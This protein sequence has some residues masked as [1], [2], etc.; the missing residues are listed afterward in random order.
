MDIIEIDA[1][2]NTGIDDIRELKE[3]VSYSPGQ[4]SRKMYI[5]DEVHM[6]STNASNALLKTLEEPPPH[7]IFVLATTEVHKML[8]TLM[9][10]CQ[11]FDFHRITHTD[12]TTKLIR[13]CQSEGIKIEPEALRLITRSASGSL[14]DAENLTEQLATYYGAEIG[15]EQTQAMLGISGD[16]RS[17]ELVGHIIDYNTAAAIKTLNAVAGDG[18][19]LKQ[20]NRELVIYLRE[21]LLFKTGSEEIL[22]LTITEKTEIETLVAKAS[23]NHILKVLKFFSSLEPELDS[24]STL[25]LELVV[26]DACLASEE[27]APK[28]TTTK[29]VLP[30]KTVVIATEAK[31]AGVA[32]K[33]TPSPVEKPRVKTKST[34]KTVT[35]T[36]PVEAT[37][38]PPT[39]AATPAIKSNGGLERLEQSWKEIIE[40]APESTRRTPALAILRSAGVHPVA[41]S[42]NTVT[43][44]FKHSYHKDKI[45]EPENK[46]VVIEVISNFLGNPCQVNCVFEREANHLV[47]EAQKLGGR[48]IDV[49]EK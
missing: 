24:S 42:D 45:E 9:S 33:A 31:P 2:S 18:L 4:A 7:V 12:I 15:L 19:D 44:S 40:Q 23:L 30:Q 20:F 37:P 22:N 43:L 39:T 11:R 32:K 46:K 13:I 14:R 38:S 6:L 21:L 8:P 47:L 29:V 49:E 28:T 16:E 10:R 48:I 1:A 35:K 5:L 36:K 34:E 3:R 17:R 41:F 27:K 26:V 25:P